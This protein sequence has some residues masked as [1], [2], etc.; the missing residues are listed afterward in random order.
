MKTPI[1]FKYSYCFYWSY[2]L[3]FLFLLFLWHHWIHKQSPVPPS[4]RV[5]EFPLWNLLVKFI[6]M[7]VV[8]PPTTRGAGLSVG[9]Y[10]DVWLQVWSRWPSGSSC[11]FP[12][13]TSSL[14]SPGRSRRWRT[15]WSCPGCCLDLPAARGRRCETKEAPSLLLSVDLTV[16]SV[17][18]WS[19]RLIVS[20]TA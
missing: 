2:F 11:P 17:K 5:N 6:L 3:F 1:F 7:L 9:S 12:P 15:R 20:N 10:W 19:C 14:G 8:F 13:E 4:L 18:I 16:N